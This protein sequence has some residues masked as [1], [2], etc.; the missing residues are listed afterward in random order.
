LAKIKTLKLKGGAKTISAVS[1][2]ISLNAANSGS[3]NLKTGTFS[4]SSGATVFAGWTGFNSTEVT[5]DGI[6]FLPKENCTLTIPANALTLG[7]K[8]LPTAALSISPDEFDFKAQGRYT[9]SITLKVVS[10]S[11]KFAGSNI[12]WDGNEL[13]FV[14]NGKGSDTSKKYQGV[15]FKWG[16]LIGISPVGDY[17]TDATTGT[18]LYWPDDVVAHTW[19]VVRGTSWSNIPYQNSTSISTT[20]RSA[21]S[22]LANPDFAAYKG[23]ICN[24]INP[25]YRMPTSTEFGNL[26]YG[27]HMT[28]TS[29]FDVPAGDDNAAGKY[30]FDKTSGKTIYGTFTTTDTSGSYV[31]PASGCHYGSDGSLRSVGYYGYYWSGS[32]SSSSSAYE[33]SFYSSSAYADTSTDRSY[34]QPVRCVLQE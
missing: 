21:H 7:G 4:S 6:T 22:L 5:S 24:Y 13:T 34:G 17:S 23:D 14:E 10:T 33:L 11:K 27:A 18:I 1:G 28:S 9:V 12:Y 32:A 30:I 31:L 26:S 29:T 15:Y 2:S 25:A 3:F 19:R 8:E 16:S 20:D